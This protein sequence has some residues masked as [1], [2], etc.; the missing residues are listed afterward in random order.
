MKRTTISILLAVG[1]LLGAE[2][3]QAQ[4]GV[5]TE[6]TPDAPGTETPANPAEASPV[7]LKRWFARIGI[8]GAAYHPG[9]SIATNGQPIPGATATVSSN[10]TTTF[11]VGYDVTK[12]ITASMCFGFPPK[13]HITGQGTVAPLGT[14]GKVRYGPAIFTGY[15]RFPKVAG[16]R[17]YAGAG[18]AYAIILKEFDAAVTQLK[19]HNNWGF[20]MQGGVERELNQK[21]DLFV[22]FKQVWLSVNA[23]GFLSGGAPVRAR[24]KLDP[25]LISVGLKFHFH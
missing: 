11:E 10:L 22:D 4:G 13:P 3:L 12:N 18:A 24:V 23:Q 21:L 9:A 5:P 7:K 15:Y 19:V 8:V 2:S 16:F 25:S 6:S 1:I 17:P 20:V 14:L